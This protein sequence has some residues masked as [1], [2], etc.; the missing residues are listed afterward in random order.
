METLTLNDGTV[1]SGHCIQ[2]DLN[3]FVY[4]YG[5]SMADGFALFSDPNK[6]IRIVENNRGNEHVYEGYTELRAINSEYGNC[7]MTMRKG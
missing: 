2:S 6:T 5:M 3:L 1:L 4:L 7:N